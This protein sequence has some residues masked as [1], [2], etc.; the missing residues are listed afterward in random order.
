MRPPG[1]GKTRQHLWIAF[2][3]S[4]EFGTA[5]AQ[6]CDIIALKMPTPKDAAPEL[7]HSLYTQKGGNNKPQV[8]HKQSRQSQA[9]KHM[10]QEE[11]RNKMRDRH[12]NKTGNSKQN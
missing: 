11:I 3:G 12:Y 7:G 4:F 2:G 9:G 1:R 6:R 5:F 10:G 8:Q